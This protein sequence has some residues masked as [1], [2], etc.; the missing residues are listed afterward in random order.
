MPVG[1]SVGEVLRLVQAFQFTDDHGEVC[2]ASWKPGDQTIKPDV[3]SA[4]EYFGRTVDDEVLDYLDTGFA[5]L[6]ASNSKSKLRKFLTKDVFLA[7]R[8]VKPR[9]RVD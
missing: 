8:L 4:M 3:S 1:R 9:Y 2:P 6:Q 5:K 7:L